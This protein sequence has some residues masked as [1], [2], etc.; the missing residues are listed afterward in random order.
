MCELCPALMAEA[1]V[2]MTP[3]NTISDREVAIMEELM[4]LCEVRGELD[5]ESNA[6]IEK[7]IAAL[8]EQLKEYDND[9]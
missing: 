8:Q 2:D 1:G 4:Y 5:P 6:R 3:V 9:S 7:Q